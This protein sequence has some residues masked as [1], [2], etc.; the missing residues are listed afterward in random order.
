MKKLILLSFSLLIMGGLYAQKD[1]AGVWYTAGKKSKIKIFQARNGKFYGKIV[2][3]E[4]P[5]AKDD[6][7]PD[8]AK[9]DKRLLDILLIQELRYDAKE[10]QWRDGTIYDPESGKTYSCYLW[11]EKGNKDIL[12]LKGY[13]M[14]MRFAGREV[15][16]TRTTL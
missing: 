6:K 13:V 2:W 5:E 16:W 3:L 14:G 4:N 15:E 9:R 1:V 10:K 12:H 11:L 8:P 7:N